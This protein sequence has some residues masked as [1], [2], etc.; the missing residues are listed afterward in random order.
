V[1]SC[2]PATAYP[3]LTKSRNPSFVNPCFPSAPPNPALPPPTSS[4]SL[5]ATKIALNNLITKH[6][7]QPNLKFQYKLQSDSPPRWATFRK[8]LSN[9]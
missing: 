2:M 8:P 5:L 6:P 4:A 9:S 7:H 3:F 1:T